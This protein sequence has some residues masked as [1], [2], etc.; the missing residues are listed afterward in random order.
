MVP[1][2]NHFLY[3]KSVKFRLQFRT[4]SNQL[5]TCFVTSELSE[6]LDETTSQVFC[7]FVPLSSV[8]VSV[9]RIKDLRINVRQFCR[10]N[11][12]EE[13]KNLSRSLVDRTVQDSIDDTTSIA[14]RDTFTSTVPTSVNQ[15]CFS[16]GLFHLLNQFF[17]IFS[18]VQ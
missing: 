14:D 11:K 16:T 4:G 13:R 18:R 15:V 10:N 2:R 7:F 6:V 17:S 3:V 8:S 9:T 12:V 5:L 1:D